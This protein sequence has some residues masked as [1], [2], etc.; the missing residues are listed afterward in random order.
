MILTSQAWSFI[1]WLT[2]SV[3]DNKVLLESKPRTA[4]PE[5]I[6]RACKIVNCFWTCSVYIKR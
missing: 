1:F 3:I 5:L 2:S 6:K 4:I